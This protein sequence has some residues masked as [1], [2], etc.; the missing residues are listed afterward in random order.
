MENV[1]HPTEN[2]EGAFL[3]NV[4]ENHLC[5][6]MLK[7][8]IQKVT[9]NREIPDWVAAYTDPNGEESFRRATAAFLSKF[10]F[11]L[12]VDPESLAFSSGATSVIEMTAFLLAEP[13]DTAVIPAPSYPVYTADIGVIPDLRR[14]DLQTHQA[15]QK[16]D[17]GIAIS[18]KDLEKAKESIEA[19]GSRFK[20]LILTSPDNP[21]GAIYSEKTIRTLADWCIAHQVHLIVNE[22]YGLS[23]LD[24]THPEIREDYPEQVSFTSFGKIMAEYRSP[25]LHFWYSFSKDFGLSGFRVGLL[26]THHE[27]LIVA[28]RNIGLSHSVSNYT[29]WVMTEVLEDEHFLEAY[30]DQYQTA[31]TTSYRMVRTTL[32][33]LD[34][35]YAP[36]YGSLFVWMNL[37][38]FLEENSQ[39]AEEKLWMK[40]YEESG[41]LLTPS[42][43][44][45]HEQKG[46]YRMVISGVDHAA[47]QVAMERL[48]AFVQNKRRIQN[49]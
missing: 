13:G 25:F 31:L 33:E 14:H 15:I 42:N 5:W 19:A 41:I 28:Y 29:Q 8:R 12:E 20:L 44:F 32:K 18:I 37:S 27:A 43:G 16:L 7:E 4:A 9:R 49:P 35:A 36:A 3:M 1:Y 11:H 2:P 24:I 46:L 23:R 40:I 47:L 48:K 6:A 38:E 10:L 17:Q 22:L 45:G 39:N 26:H 34:I 30:F 21:T